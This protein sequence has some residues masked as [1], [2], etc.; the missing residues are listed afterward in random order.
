M[1][2]L[3]I[4]DPFQQV[5]KKEPV[6]PVQ[7]ATF[8]LPFCDLLLLRPVITLHISHLILIYRITLPSYEYAC[9]PTSNKK[10]QIPSPHAGRWDVKPGT[11]P[12]SAGIIDKLGVEMLS[13]P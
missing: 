8:N 10:I 2:D 6:L 5:I 12:I 7:F 11:L 1:L 13:E 4:T 3:T 9:C